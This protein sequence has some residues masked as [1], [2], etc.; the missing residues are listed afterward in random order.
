[1]DKLLKR[2]DVPEVRGRREKPAPVSVRFGLRLS[3]T[4][5][6]ALNGWDAPAA[7]EMIELDS[8]SPQSGDEPSHWVSSSVRSASNLRRFNGPRS[9]RVVTLSARNRLICSLRDILNRL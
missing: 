4:Y 7:T 8:W 6:M 9:W 2:D 5:L 1:M 3:D